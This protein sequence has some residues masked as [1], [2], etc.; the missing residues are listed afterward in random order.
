MAGDPASSLERELNYYRRECND[1][2]ARLLRLQEEQSQAFREARRSRTLVKLLREAYRLGDVGTSARDVGGPMLELVV[3]NALCD[4]AAFLREEPCGSG[5]FLI[6]HAIGLPASALTAVVAV[7]SPP[8]FFYTSSRERE[9]GAHPVLAVLDVP[10]VLWA[11]DRATGHALVIGNRSEGNVNRPFEVGDQ[12]L[13]EGALS[14]YLDVLNRKHAEAQLRQA[15]QMAETAIAAKAASLHALAEAVQRPLEAIASLVVRLA[16]K[17]QSACAVEVQRHAAEIQAIVARAVEAPDEVAAPAPL[18]LE[19]LAADDVVRAALRTTYADCLRRGVEV[20][21]RMPRRPIAMLADQQ[22]M[23]DAVHNLILGVLDM[24][25][26]GGTIRVE[27]S[28]RGDG[29]MEL[30][31]CNRLPGPLPPD[32]PGTVEG[33]RPGAD[34]SAL[35]FAR[36]AVDAHGGTLIF[37]DTGNGL[38]QARMLLPPDNIRDIDLTTTRPRN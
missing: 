7:A 20:N 18:S 19:W 29:G 34:V 30:F 38:S 25:P 28:R 24:T 4:R 27:L 8:S 5:Q 17:H 32:F 3:D 13:I 36:K 33:V 14:I 15:K 31:I 2:G 10:F 9:E 22:H 21:A 12:E 23:R 26:S 35:V 37:E 11:Y 1:L 16:E 6:V